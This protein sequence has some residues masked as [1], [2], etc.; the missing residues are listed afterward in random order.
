MIRSPFFARF[1]DSLGMDMKSAEM[2]CASRGQAVWEVDASGEEI[3]D[4]CIA[5]GH[6]KVS[7][8]WQKQR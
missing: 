4:I 1:V 8:G 6:G 7:G 5:A 3:S 2:V